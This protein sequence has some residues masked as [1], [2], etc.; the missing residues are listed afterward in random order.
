MAK[1]TRKI[2]SKGTRNTWT[3]RHTHIPPTHTENPLETKP[4]IVHISKRSV[5]D[6]MPQQS[7]VGPKKKIDPTKITLSLF[8]VSHLLLDMYHALK[9]GLS[10]Q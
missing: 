9:C 1:Q 10:T 2:Q 8:C 5:T 6:K 7:T 4:E 3:L